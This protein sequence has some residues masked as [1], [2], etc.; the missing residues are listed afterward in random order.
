M[1]CFLL[2]YLT[3]LK[4]IILC[5]DRF[6]VKPLFYH[7]D[8][9]NNAFYF[10]SEIKGLHAAGIDK[11]E[12]E[13]TWSGFLNY[14]IYNNDE[15]TFWEDINLLQ[16]GHLIELKFKKTISKKIIRWYNFEQSCLS[17]KNSL[18]FQNKSSSEH[19]L[20][21]KELLINSVKNRFRSDVK[22]G[23]TLSGGVD[24]SI[25]YKT[26]SDLFPS[27]K[28]ESFTFQCNNKKYDELRMG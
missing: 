28:I 24:S 11:N 5:R 14:G 10:A 1:G 18:S 19:L 27:L 13:A 16:P 2:L 21:Y 9:Q 15:Q 26:I 3:I 8:R 17:I 6:G 12:N 25:L 4:K 20:H 22:V 7:L 23:F